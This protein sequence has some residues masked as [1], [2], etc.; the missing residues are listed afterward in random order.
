[1]LCAKGFAKPVAI[2][3]FGVDLSAFSPRETGTSAGLQPPTI[4]FFGRML[5]GKGLNVLAQALNKIA[6][7]RWNLLVV[8]DGPERTSFAEALSENGLLDRAR[9]TGAVPFEKIPELYREIDLL[10]MPTETTDRIRE[11]F[12][13]VLVEAMASGVPVIGSTC[14]A[15]PEVIGEAGMVFPERDAEALALAM[16]RLLTD[17][18]LRARLSEQGKVRVRQNYSWDVV[19]TKTYEFFQQVLTGTATTDLKGRQPETIR[20]NQRESAAA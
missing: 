16:R 12:G 2:I 5:P 9:F 6:S 8:G 19:A 17:A 14:G 10:V 3:P 1:V 18:A 15:I 20:F 4:G 11:Q 7:E 13:R